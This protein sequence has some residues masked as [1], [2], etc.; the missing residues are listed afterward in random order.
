MNAALAHVPGPH[1]ALRPGRLTDVDALAALEQRA[2]R[3]DRIS[4][5]GFRQFVRSPR[6]ALIVAAREA[7]SLGFIRSPSIRILP[8]AVSDRCCSA[9][10]R[11]RRSRMIAS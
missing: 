1:L 11:M 7:G 6:A 8:A 2:F 4:R 10:R 9:P 3:G 5:R